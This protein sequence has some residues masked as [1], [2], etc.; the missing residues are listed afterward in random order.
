MIV[1][2]RNVYYI[3]QQTIQLLLFL[4]G[5]LSRTGSSQ[6]SRE[7][8]SSRSTQGVRSIG[9]NS[10]NMQKSASHSKYQQPM[11]S[12]SASRM[13]GKMSANSGAASSNLYRDSQQQHQSYFSSSTSSTTHQHF[14][15]AGSDTSQHS[16][17]SPPAVFEEPTS[18]DNKVITAVVEEMIEN[19]ANSKCIDATT[20]SCLNT[21]K[22]NL[23]C[24]LLYYI[25]TDYLHLREV[26]PM[27]R[28]HLA[29][30]VAYLIEKK[31]ISVDHF[32][33]AYKHFAELASDLIVDIPELWLYIFEFTGK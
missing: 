4:L 9:G 7:N 21:V 15:P 5:L 31:Y 25:L 13:T 2:F 30:V 18:A 27:G 1:R 29:N 22:E 19:A 10:S 8:S 16:S 24:G 20:V 11:S 33:L 26:D 14:N 28:R 12:L 17:G 23:R 32:R 6:A 3:Q